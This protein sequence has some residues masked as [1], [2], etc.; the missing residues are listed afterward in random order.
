MPQNNRVPQGR[1]CLLSELSLISVKCA[2]LVPTASLQL[3]YGL[4]T[5]YLQLTYTPT[6]YNNTIYGTTMFRYY[7]IEHTRV[8]SSPH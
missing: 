3:T 5:A 2:N 6:Q 4:P 7:M 1:S 8:G